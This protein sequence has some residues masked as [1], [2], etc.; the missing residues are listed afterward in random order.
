MKHPEQSAVTLRRATITVLDDGSL[1]VTLDG[2]P[3]DGAAEWLAVGE[4][5]IRAVL[6]ALAGAA[7]QTVRV[8]IHLPGGRH[9]VEYL[10]PD[11]VGDGDAP[12]SASPPA[13]AQPVRRSGG[14]TVFGVA[15]QGFRPG[16]VV[17]VAVVV[18]ATHADATGLATLRMPPGLLA[19][20]PLE[21]MLLGHTSGVVVVHD[22]HAIPQVAA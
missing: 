21:L 16:E 13:G 22:P 9:L 18:A 12:A 4:P 15:E 2:E 3:F 14:G 5:A 8:D 7:G 11:D 10:T 1:A 19:G 6:P 20:R 17:S